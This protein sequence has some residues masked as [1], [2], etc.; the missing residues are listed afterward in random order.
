MQKLTRND[1]KQ[2]PLFAGCTDDELDH[3]SSTMREAAA[4]QGGVLTREGEPSDSLYVVAEGRLEV[5]VAGVHRRV[6]EPGDYF[7]EISLLDGGPA[8]ATVVA[9]TPAQLMTMSDA[10]F[11][12]AISRHPMLL[13]RVMGTMAL[14]LRRDYKEWQSQRSS[15]A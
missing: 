9:Q 13:K 6:L 4:K 2:V 1:L 14:Y 15:S 5:K 7:G 11:R 8:T 3:L 12:E 10:D